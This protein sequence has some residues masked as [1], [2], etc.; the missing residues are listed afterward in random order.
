MPRTHTQVELS[1]VVLLLDCC[2]HGD[3][4]TFKQQTW[5]VWLCTEIA[6]DIDPLLLV[7]MSYHNQEL[8]NETGSTHQTTPVPTKPSHTFAT[9]KTEEEIHNARAKR[10]PNKS[11]EDTKYCIHLWNEWKRHR[12]EALDNSIPDL[13]ELSQCELQHWLTR[14]VL[15]VRKEDGSEFVPNMLHHICCIT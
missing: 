13:T 10:I 2:E 14:F 7:A 3:G 15:E 9:P 1:R 6:D 8:V 12:Q 11:V 5:S 4:T